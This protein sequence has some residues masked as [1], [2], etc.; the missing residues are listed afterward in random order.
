MLPADD[1]GLS[2]ECALLSHDLSISGRL[3]I[4][5]FLEYSAQQVEVCPRIGL[6]GHPDLLGRFPDPPQDDGRVTLE[7]RS[8]VFAGFGNH[9]LEGGCKAIGWRGRRPVVVNDAPRRRFERARERRDPFDHVVV[10]DRLQLRRLVS[11][12]EAVDHEEQLRLTLTEIA[13][14]V[15]EQVDVA[16]LPTHG[17]RRR[18]VAR[19]GE[20]RTVR[21]TGNLDETLRAAAH[22]ANLVSERRAAS[23]RAPFVAQRTNHL[24]SIV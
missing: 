22:G 24:R 23:S 5:V 11:L 10:D 18:M 21:G 4:P 8:S 19:G 1:G 16:L 12:K 14:P 13:H 15:R 3:G 9:G 2:A 6:V 7:R 20:V 17:H